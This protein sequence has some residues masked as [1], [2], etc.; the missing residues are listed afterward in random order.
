MDPGCRLVRS[1]TAR[2]PEHLSAVWRRCPW[3]H[4]TAFDLPILGR[5]FW[6]PFK[7]RVCTAP[8]QRSNL[9]FPWG[10]GALSFLPLHFTTRAVYPP[11][12][13]AADLRVVPQTE[14]H[15]LYLLGSLWW[16]LASGLGPLVSVHESSAWSRWRRLPF[17]LITPFEAW[18]MTGRCWMRQGFS[19]VNETCLLFKYCFYSEGQRSACLS[20]SNCLHLVRNRQQ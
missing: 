12:S 1:L 5:A 18:M 9:V 19:E 8:C 14:R 3:N 7:G 10:R 11:T 20:N 2:Q 6:R 4:D 13:M 17:S 15:P 16:V